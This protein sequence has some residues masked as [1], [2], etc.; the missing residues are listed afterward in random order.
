[1]VLGVL[2]LSLS[3]GD[4]RLIFK[5]F[6]MKFLSATKII[7]LIS[8]LTSATAVFS[9][10]GHGFQGIHWHATDTLGCIAVAAMVAVAVWLS[11]K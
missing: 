4:G 2:S 11:R 3:R 10:E 7:A 8:G 1:M 9:H 5:E 6:L